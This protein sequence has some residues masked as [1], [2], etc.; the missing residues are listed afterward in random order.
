[1]NKKINPER[2]EKLIRSMRESVRIL[3]EI[4][5]MQ[6]SEYKGEIP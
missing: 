1:M 3:R 6:K 2:V 5:N 4:Q